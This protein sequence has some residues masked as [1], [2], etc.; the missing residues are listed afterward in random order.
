MCKCSQVVALLHLDA[1]Y[2]AHPNNGLVQ[3][4]AGNGQ[5]NTRPFEKQTNFSGFAKQDYFTQKNPLDWQKSLEQFA[6][7]PLGL[8]I[9]YKRK[10]FL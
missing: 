2:S 3:I 1:L 6:N 7:S 5:P 9:L 10:I 4:S 8:T